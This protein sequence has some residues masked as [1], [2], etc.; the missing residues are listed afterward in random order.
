MKLRH[1]ILSLGVAGVLA[2]VS[3]MAADTETASSDKPKAKAQ[4]E[5]VTATRIRPSPKD[6]CKSAAT[7]SRSYS[8]E[9]IERTGEIDMGEALRKI[10]PIFR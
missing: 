5:S 4:C 2:P 7:P 1:L 10:D 3:L 9:E 6:G 8:R